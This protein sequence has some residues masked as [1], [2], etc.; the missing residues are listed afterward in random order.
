MDVR[1]ALRWFCSGPDDE[2]EDEDG[3]E[4]EWSGL[5]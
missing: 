2:V 5:R 4:D 3:D 1:P